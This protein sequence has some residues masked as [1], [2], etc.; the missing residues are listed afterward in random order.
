MWK[1]GVVAFAAVSLASCG[2][3]PADQ[4]LEASESGEDKA[5]A[6]KAS[7]APTSFALGLWRPSTGHCK[8]LVD[9]EITHWEVK[10]YI[11]DREPQVAEVKFTENDGRNQNI[12]VDGREVIRVHKIDESHIELISDRIGNCV[13][14]RQ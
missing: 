14:V 12:T 6:T 4:K 8:E 13:L 11:A 1:L 5:V 3:S 7:G 2:A 10:N 9:I